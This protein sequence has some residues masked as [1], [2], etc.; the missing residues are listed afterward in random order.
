[1]SLIISLTC[2]LLATMLQQ[3]ARRYHRLTGTRYSLHKRA[4][5]RT[6]FA[7]GVKKAHLP[8]AVEALPGLLH[9]SVFLFFAGLPIFLFGTNHTVFKAV[10]SCVGASGLS[11]LLIAIMPLAFHDSPYYTPLSTLFWALYVGLRWLC[12]ESS[13]LVVKSAVKFKVN[14]STRRPWPTNNTVRSLTTEERMELDRLRGGPVKDMRSYAH[15]SSREIDTRTLSWAFDFVDDEDELEQILA[16][17]PGFYKSS[18]VTDS[19]EILSETSETI[20]SA[21]LQLMDRSLSSDLVDETRRQKRSTVCSKVLEILPELQRATMRQSIGFIGTDM[22]KWIELGLLANQDDSFEAKCVT[23]LI[24]A[25]T[26]GS[27]ERWSSAMMHQLGLSG[28]ISQGDDLLLYNLLDFVRWMIFHYNVVPHPDYKLVENVLPALRRFSVTSASPERQH[29][30]CFMWNAILN[31]Q[32]QF[33]QATDFMQHAGG[34]DV[35]HRA[36]IEAP[37]LV[38]NLTRNMDQNL[39]ENFVE[40]FTRLF[41]Q[42]PTSLVSLIPLLINHIS[43]LYDAL[44]PNRQAA[45]ARGPVSTDT[46]GEYRTVEPLYFCDEPSHHPAGD[47]V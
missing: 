35:F 42:N 4:R 21:V 1:M 17:I 13:K 28:H 23:A 5:I 41:V 6:F 26:R 10:L 16:S 27:D 12:L 44:H 43:T 14:L 11:Y 29:Q 8:W 40:E 20:S 34:Y 24:T 3:W 38:R 36:R 9:A 45:Q 31:F 7:R 32:E 47:P 33:G 19:R 39:P 46:W 18:L 2:A 22:F 15:R 25:H 37:N 30:F